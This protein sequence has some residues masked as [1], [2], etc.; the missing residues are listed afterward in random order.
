[1]RLEK[2]SRPIF[3]VFDFGIESN[4]GRISRI[5]PTRSL[6]FLSK[7]VELILCR[8]LPQAQNHRPLLGI[9]LPQGNYAQ[10]SQFLHLCLLNAGIDGI[11][12]SKMERHTVFT[13]SVP[14]STAILFI[15]NCRDYC[16]HY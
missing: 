11:I 12:T 14:L 5:N 1:M 3:A 6:I 10:F 7:A 2:T 16:V 8:I 4:K 15:N 9:Q 13:W